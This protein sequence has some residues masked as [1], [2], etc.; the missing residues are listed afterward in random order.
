M[1]NLNR[2]TRALHRRSAQADEIPKTVNGD[3]GPRRNP[4]APP[5]LASTETGTGCTCDS[6]C[7]RRAADSWR[8]RLKDSTTQSTER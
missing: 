2:N 5:L 8:H 7:P 3:G 1:Q 6:D 4:Y